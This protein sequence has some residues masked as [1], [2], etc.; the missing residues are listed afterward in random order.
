MTIKGSLQVSI[1]I[2]KAFLMRKCPIEIGKKFVFGGNCGRNVKFC[3]QDSLCETT[4]F[5]VLS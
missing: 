5:D 3:F 2:V 4:S 1:P